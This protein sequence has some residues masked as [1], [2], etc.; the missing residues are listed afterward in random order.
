MAPTLIDTN[1]LVYAYDRSEPEKQRRALEVLDSLAHSGDGCLSA[2]VLSEFLVN[3]TRKIATPLTLV[4]AEARLQ[5]YVKI[6]PVFPVSSQVV[7]EAIRGVRYYQLSFWDAQIWAAARLH[8]VP[9]VLSE[10]FNPG[11]VLEGVRFVDPFAA[12]FRVQDLAEDV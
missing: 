9:T 2:Q 4:Q 12:E 11:A 6:W 5:H 3:V 1:V 7:L 10:D 8:H